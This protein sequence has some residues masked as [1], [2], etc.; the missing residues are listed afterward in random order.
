MVAEIIGN[1]GLTEGVVTGDRREDVEA[2]KR[3]RSGQ[4]ALAM[5]RKMN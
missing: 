1:L 2:A 5:A 3:T 4:W